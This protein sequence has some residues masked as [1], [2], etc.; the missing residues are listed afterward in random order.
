MSY[1]V[2]VLRRLSTAF[3]SR[4]DAVDRLLRAEKFVDLY[5]IARAA[6]RTSEPDLSLKTL[7]VFF[8]DKRIEDVKKA[9]QS[10]VHYHRW[11]ETGDQA[12][13]DGILAYNKVDCE[14]TEGLRNWLVALRPDLPW[15]TKPGPPPEP[16]KSKEA[17]EREFRREALR[18]A[19]RRGGRRLSDR[20]RELMAY[21][22]DFYAR[23]KKPEQ[24]AVFDRCSREPDERSDDAECM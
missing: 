22:V 17:A 11:R 4:E 8:A 20:G 15:W 7:E 9:D 13:L 5:A 23:A 14:N 6:L 21:L 10:I 18:L 12:L 24:W 16:E 19:V 3:A 2:T 1:E